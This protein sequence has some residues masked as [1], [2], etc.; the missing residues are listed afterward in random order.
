MG[1]PATSDDL[2]LCNLM[3]NQANNA[4]PADVDLKR[5]ITVAAFLSAAHSCE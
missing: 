1:R 3:L 4:D 5:V 2:I